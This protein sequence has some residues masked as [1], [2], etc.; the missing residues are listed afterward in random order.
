MMPALTLRL[1]HPLDDTS[2]SLLDAACWQR[3]LDTL[4]DELSAHYLADEEALMQR[5]VDTLAI[6]TSQQRDVSDA[7]AALINTA[8]RQKHRRNL[9]DD[10][11]QQYSLNTHEGVQLMC[12]AEALLRVPDKATSNALIEDKLGQADW[13]AHLGKSEA[14][15]VNASSWGL[16]LTGRVLTLDTP[17]NGQPAGALN[18]LITRLGEPVIR[19]VMLKMMRIMGHQFVLG[20]DMPEA[21]KRSRARLSQRYTYSYDMLGEAALTAQDAERYFSA[22]HAAI[23]A[24]GQVAPTLARETPPPSISIKLSAL[25]PRYSV[26]QQARVM[27]EL[28]ITV[29]RLVR[30]ARALGVALTVD[31]EEADRL[32]LSLAL[33][34][35]VYRSPDVQGWGQFGLVVQAYSKRAFPT[36][37]WLTQL[38]DQ[39]GDEIPVRLVKGAYWDSEI[40]LAQQLGLS[41]Y[42]VFTRKAGTDVS[43][44]ACARFL[45]SDATRGRLFPQFGSHNAHTLASIVAMAGDRRFEVQRLHGM[46]EV[47]HDALLTQAPEGMYC[48]IYAPVGAHKDLLPYLVRRLLENGANSSFVHQ[49]LNPHI[50]A[51]QLSQHPLA[52]LAAYPTYAS[53]RITLP[54]T[55]FGPRRLAAKGINM[56]IRHTF[57]EM[58]AAMQPFMAQDTQWHAAPQLGEGGTPQGL[59][60]QRVVS[61]YDHAQP[62]GEVQFADAKTTETAID[63]AARAFPGWNATPVEQRAVILERYADILEAHMPELVALCAREAGK[64]LND[65]IA[66]VREAVD[67]CRY[68]ADQARLQLAHAIE[69]PGPTGE[70]NTLSQEGRGV[71][72]TI[73]PWNFPIAIFIGQTLAAAVAGNTVIAKPAEQT[74][75]CAYRAME[76]LYDA[77][78]P[79]DVVQCLPGRGAVIGDVLTRDPRI[80]GVAFTGSNAT[81]THIN[82]ALAQ[83]EMA[84]LPVLIAETGGLNA[85]LVD[86]T[87]L[88]EQVIRDVI[89]SAFQSAGQRCS[90]LRMLYV[91]EDIAD[92]IVEALEGA[93]RELVIGDP[94]VLKTDVGPVIDRRAGDAL[95]AYVDRFKAAGQVLFE[96]PMPPTLTRQGSFV[97]PVALR[98]DGIGDLDGEQ[99]GPILHVATYK[100]SEV[101]QVLDAIN[102]KGYGLTFGLHTRNQQFAEY[103]AQR[104]RV[105]NVYVNRN[106]I[107]AVVGVQPFGGCGLSGTGPKAGG[108]HYLQRFVTEKTRT[109]NTAAQGGNASLLAMG[110]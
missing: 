13:R 7:T 52:Q 21:L 1:P 9:L 65:G 98:V 8:R 71:F 17:Q 57:D 16:L 61:P 84:A 68:Y 62:V 5:L 45:L 85:M 77:G 79:R 47:L 91:Q 28:A 94:C 54:R 101:D 41:G 110:D 67:F 97:A 69:L 66:D 30:H 32:E 22:Y 55:I 82:R 89:E 63:I 34:E 29:R 43:Y 105:G 23:T 48:R 83:R 78:M 2:V 80:I 99:F 92:G 56:N 58:T 103:V 87:A 72:A 95:T 88:P 10:L 104:V 33:F 18:R 108:P 15:L 19:K 100:A 90:A 73:S 70:R 39:Q 46:G 81:A 35:Q 44:L 36:L 74:S 6:S 49:L 76:L 109:V 42:P 102:A 4:M 40:K 24:A 51:E 20:R 107:G 93:M 31:A 27:H 12:L 59:E 14:W 86:A 60:A 3:P 53:T 96:C 37:F 25:H 64:Q 38:S 106:T 11:L 26:G 75:L 50:P